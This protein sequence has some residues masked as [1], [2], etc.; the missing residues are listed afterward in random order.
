MSQQ[1]PTPAEQ[2]AAVEAEARVRLDQGKRTLEK[3]KALE[4]QEAE[5]TALARIRIQTDQM[6][7]KQTEQ[8]RDAEQ[9]AELAAIERRATDLDAA[10]EARRKTDLERDA[11]AATEAKRVALE[12]SEAAARERLAALEVLSQQRAEQRKNL[13]ELKVAAASDRSLRWQVRWLALRLMSPAKLG[14]V[15]LLIGAVLGAAVAY[16]ELPRSET[17]TQSALSDD[18]ESGVAPVLRLERELSSR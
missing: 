14:L 15:T 7:A 18:W 16:F 11:A 3:L 1:P 17:Q 10:K 8:L 5:A 9:K 13:A 2:R 6:L 4:L 12:A